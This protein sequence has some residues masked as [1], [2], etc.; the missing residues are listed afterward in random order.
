[1][2]RILSSACRIAAL[3]ACGGAAAEVADSA[4]VPVEGAD[5][6]VAFRAGGDVRL[7]QEGFDHVMIK[8]D[9]PAVTRG[10]H[11]DYFR[12]RTRANAGVDIGEDV[13]LDARLAN[14]VRSRNAGQRSYEWPDELIV[15]Q[16]KLALRGLLDGR[17]DLS[18]GRQDAVL[19][20]GRLF[21]EGT[22]KDGSRTQFFDGALARIRLAEKTTLDVFGFHGACENE[23]AAGHEHRD[24]TGYVGGFTGMDEASAGFFLDDR[25][26]DALGWGLYYVWKHDTAWHRP[27]GAAEPHED[28]HTVGAR[29]LPRLSETV[30]AELEGAYQWSG[31]DGYDRRAGFAFGS[32][33]Y[34]PERP[35]TYVSANA[36]T[37][38]G[39]DPD[40]ARREDFNVLYG[41]YPWISELLLY[42][43]DG[44]GVGTWHNLTQA[45]VEVGHA[46]GGKGAHKLKATAGP[47]YA[48]ESDGAGG[49]HERGWL[50]TLFYAFPVAKGRF[51]DL[52]GHLFLEVFEPGDYYVSDRTAYFFRWQL[53]WAF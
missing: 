29:L 24:L 19:G 30:G 32:L 47:V 7:R 11:N 53:N 10:G 5:S 20:S 4:S 3:L 39:D 2:K 40:T 6:R 22:A 48:P 51:G 33:R 36:L 46:F 14:E 45:W 52:T 23:L 44:D 12:I 41:R 35:G 38:T 15:D 8:G 34:A 49:G 43:F 18:L 26:A 50:E 31:S 27:D 37:L 17:V 42:G 13:S 1:M 16:L 25:S 28:I 9:E 21:A